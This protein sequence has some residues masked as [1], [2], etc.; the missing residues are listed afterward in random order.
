MFLLV[1]QEGRFFSVL[2]LSNAYQQLEVDESRP[3]LTINIHLYFP[4]GNRKCV[5]RLPGVV[6]YLDDVLIVGQLVGDCKQNVSEILERLNHYNITINVVKCQFLCESVEYVEREID[7][8]GVHPTEHKVH[9]IEKV[10]V[11]T[12]I[13]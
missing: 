11:P 3:Y 1:W 6:C 2:D 9:A 12:N 10:P 4:T 7:K 5:A 8:F 13:T